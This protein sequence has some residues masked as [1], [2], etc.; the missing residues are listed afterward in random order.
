MIKT[1]K[2]VGMRDMIVLK[3]FFEMALEKHPEGCFLI[4]NF[5]CK[6]NLQLNLNWGADIEEEKETDEKQEQLKKKLMM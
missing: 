6:V 3:K 5:R 2:V 4:L 1:L